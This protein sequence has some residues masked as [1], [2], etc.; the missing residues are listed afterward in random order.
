MWLTAA[1]HVSCWPS[2]LRSKRECVCHRW[3]GARPHVLGVYVSDSKGLLRVG[4]T[5]VY[6]CWVEQGRT[7]L[8]KLQRH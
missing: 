4:T 2:R 7:R 1:Q 8:L 3:G 5:H 6:K